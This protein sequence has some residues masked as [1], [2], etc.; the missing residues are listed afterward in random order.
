MNYQ[1]SYENIQKSKECYLK[2]LW[3]YQDMITS[4]KGFGH[5]LDY[6][7]IDYMNLI[8]TYTEDDI[9][10]SHISSIISEGALVAL[11][12]AA[13]NLLDEESRSPSFEAKIKKILASDMITYFKDTERVLNKIISAFGEEV[14]LDW[15]TVGLGKVLKL[16]L[17]SLYDKYVI[18][19]YHK[20]INQGLAKY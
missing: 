19:Y 12:C 9:S 6:E 2:V 3:L 13:V 17:D 5:N 20:M 4:Y 15:E 8:F 14:R 7:D 16:E 18:G 11:C 1:V 10:Y